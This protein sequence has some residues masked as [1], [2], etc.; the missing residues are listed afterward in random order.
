MV[1]QS[2]T[3]DTIDR[4]IGGVSPAFALL[5]GMQLDIFTTLKDGPKTTDEV[6]VSLDVA[7]VKLALLL[8]ALVAAGLLTLEGD[9]F[10]NTLEAGH[11]LVK[12]I[13]D[14]RGYMQTALADQW[15]NLLKTADSV[16]AGVAQAKLDF[17]AMSPDEAQAHRRRRYSETFAAGKSL[18]NR[19]DFSGYQTMAD[20]AGGS[21]ALS[22]AITEGHPQLKS[23]IIDLPNV[24]EAAE[25]F[26]KEAGAEN[27]VDISPADVVKAPLTGSYDVVVMRSFIQVLG[28]EDARRAL[29]NV[30]GI[31]K[32]G[33]DLL[34]LGRVLD[35]SRI[36]PIDVVTHNV[37]FLNL[38]D[39]GQAYTEGEHREWLAE[40][41]FEDFSREALPDAM[42]LI[43][44]RRRA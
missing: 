7:P 30:A 21:G 22:I 24:S 14:Y 31:V 1:M 10:S 13:P 27:R 44:A 8:Y 29:K 15:S 41:G 23:T 36:S 35:D 33:G 34:I 18:I 39:G 43:S 16:K 37:L 3:P 5:A 32:P 17:S 26:V 20:V 38:Y 6:A 25:R 40:A 9:R 11:F 2:P 12:G 4:L 19:R 28:A 42:S